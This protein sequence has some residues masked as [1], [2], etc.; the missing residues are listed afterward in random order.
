M[1][2]WKD[3]LLGLGP[4]VSLIIATVACSYFF[5]WFVWWMIVI[6]GAVSILAGL[7]GALYL[8]VVEEERR[9]QAQREH[10][11]DVLFDGF[12]TDDVSRAGR[13]AEGLLN[14]EFYGFSEDQIATLYGLLPAL[15]DAGLARVFIKEDEKSHSG[16]HLSQS[17]RARLL[18]VYMARG[19]IGFLLVDV[20]G[21]LTYRSVH[22]ESKEVT[23]WRSVFVEAVMR[24]TLVEGSVSNKSTALELLLDLEDGKSS[25]PVFFKPS[26]MIREIVS[27]AVED[28]SGELAVSVLKNVPLPKRLDTVRHLWAHVLSVDVEKALPL[29]LM[30]GEAP[31]VLPKDM[32]GDVLAP[33]L[34]SENAVV[35]LQL[36]K[37][38]R[39]L[40]PL[41]VTDAETLVRMCLRIGPDAIRT[42]LSLHDLPQRCRHLV[43]EEVTKS[44]NK[45]LAR[46]ALDRV[47]DILPAHRTILREMVDKQ[48]A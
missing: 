9:R 16:I 29:I 39:K 15:N 3:Y 41:P 25:M 40:V 36:L 35:A 42:L 2:R 32:R 38:P 1:L 4:F 44:G 8:I 37:I 48:V 46:Y 22:D 13:A 43:L 21:H 14:R 27:Q 10:S 28:E 33:V 47:G 30:P 6:L 26:D 7:A 24:R 34:A 31:N 12:P 18:E 20:C 19:D 5:D 45:E 17:T 11:W 23:E